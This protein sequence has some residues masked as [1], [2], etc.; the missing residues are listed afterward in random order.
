MLEDEEELTD[1]EVVDSYGT[2]T[3]LLLEELIVVVVVVVVDPWYCEGTSLL[4][5]LDIIELE[6]IELDIDDDNE[7]K[8]I[9]LDIIDETELETGDWTT[10]LLLVEPYTGGTSEDELT[11]DALL[12]APGYAG[13]P[14]N[15]TAIFVV[16]GKYV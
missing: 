15:L 7:L 13:L 8:T 12:D 11:P 14:A 10:L 5:E 9:E 6:T 3:S 2:G 4:E 16:P 1:E